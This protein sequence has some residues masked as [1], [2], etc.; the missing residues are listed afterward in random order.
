MNGRGFDKLR[1]VAA[2]AAPVLA[3]LFGAVTRSAR[4]STA[5]PVTYSSSTHWQLQSSDC[6]EAFGLAGQTC[7]LGV[8]Q[9]A[10]VG[11]SAL[12]T[13]YVAPATTFMPPPSTTPATSNSPAPTPTTPPITNST[14][15]TMAPPTT[16][17]SPP[18]DDD[19]DG[20]R[21]RRTPRK[22]AKD[23]SEITAFNNS[24]GVSVAGHVFQAPA[25]RVAVSGDT[26]TAGP[27]ML[28]GVTTRVQYRFFGPSHTVRAVYMFTNS[29]TAPVVL[30][31][32]TN[33]G[34]FGGGGDIALDSGGTPHLNPRSRWYETTGASSGS[35]APSV[36]FVDAGVIGVSTVHSIAR[37]AFSNGVLHD[38]A[39]FRI[40]VGAGATQALMVFAQAN[41]APLTAAAVDGTFA[42][43]YSL[44][45]AGLLGNLPVPTAQISNW[46][47]TP[48]PFSL[49]KPP[50]PTAKKSP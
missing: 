38:V 26:V 49:L 35:I 37:Y 14:Q 1:I 39:T 10:P 43:L 4:A 18:S 30:D 11:D 31:V 9:F 28:G 32:R 15:P 2:S 3:S 19:M 12:P 33:I 8:H 29:S 45:S 7:G 50:S 36:L 24:L 47:S 20:K 34:G 6:A 48:L 21:L 41:S 25:G 46:K 23:I 17:A 5:L 13:T 22:R 42:D 44:D 16:T 40:E 27:S